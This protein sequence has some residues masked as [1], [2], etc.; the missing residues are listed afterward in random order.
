MV[1]KSV[2][3]VV[4][5]V[6]LAAPTFAADRERASRET[7]VRGES[8]VVRVARAIKKVVSLGD[9]IVMPKP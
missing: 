6:F 4:V 2:V 5:L 7:R 1:R 9:G 3:L 8:F